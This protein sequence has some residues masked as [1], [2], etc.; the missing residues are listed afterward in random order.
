MTLEIEQEVFRLL[1]EQRARLLPDVTAP[2][3]LMLSQRS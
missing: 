1:L 3:D 2:F